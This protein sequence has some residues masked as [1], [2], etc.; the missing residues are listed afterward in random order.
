M[1]R[2]VRLA[3]NFASGF[4]LLLMIS[5]ANEASLWI[6]EEEHEVK[7]FRGI[8]TVDGLPFSGYMFKLY[9]A[10][11]TA[12]IQQ[13]FNGKP[14]GVL[15]EWYDNLVLKELR[16]FDNGYKTGMHR[17]WY[18]NGI[19]KFTANF[20]DDMYDGNVKEWQ[21]NGN[22][23]RDFNYVDGHESGM[24]RM[25][26]SDGRLKANYEVREGRKFGLAGNKNCLSINH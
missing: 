5:C 16:Y 12:R 20:R 4:A 15:K 23:Y 6:N 1:E 24:Q 2:Q 17:G 9:P 22:L 25:W 18:E 13:F 26:E 11:D 10:G 14:H 7:T 21:A 8:T 19:N 3:T